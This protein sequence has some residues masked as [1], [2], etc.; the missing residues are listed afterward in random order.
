MK[1]KKNTVYKDNLGNFFFFLR[2]KIP[3]TY[4][5]GT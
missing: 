2:H 1:L 5:G 3:D 4:I